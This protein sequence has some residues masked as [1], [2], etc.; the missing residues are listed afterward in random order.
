VSIA[1]DPLFA[2]A[3]STVDAGRVCWW[4][5]CGGATVRCTDAANETHYFHPQCWKRFV[6]AHNGVVE[7]VAE[8]EEDD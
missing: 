1:K 3:V 6:D 5:D 8:A 7:D 2:A 4:C